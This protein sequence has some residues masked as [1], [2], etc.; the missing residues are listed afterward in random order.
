[1]PGNLKPFASF[2]KRPFGGVFLFR[3][4]FWSG[5][6]LCLM[7]LSW[8]S[9]SHYRPWVNFEAEFLSFLGLAML[10]LASLAAQPRQRWPLPALCLAAL[11]LLPF[12]QLAAGILTFAGDAFVGFVYVL[13]FA[14]SFAIGSS[15]GRRRQLPEDIAWPWLLVLGVPAFLSALVGVLQWAQL[16]DVLGIYAV[17]LDLGDRPMGNMGQPNQ[18]ATLLVMG[19]CAF[20]YLFE[21][22]RSGKLL[23]LTVATVITVVLAFTQ[24]RAGLLGATLAAVFL[25]LKLR[26]T[27]ARRL[28]AW[29]APA[30]L[31]AT[32][33]LWRAGSW[34]NDV[35]LTEANR[36]IGLV[37]DNSRGMIYLQ[38]LAGV[39][40]APALGYGWNQTTTA[41]RNGAMVFPGNL[42]YNNAHSIVVDL[43]AWAGVP[44]GLMIMFGLVA[45]FVDRAARVKHTPAVL[46]TAALIPFAVHSLFEFPFA[47]A[48]FLLSAGLLAGYVEGS[49]EA[50]PQRV[51]GALE[52]RR[53]LALAIALAWGC[54]GMTLSWSYL[55]VQRDF[56][57]VRFENLRI[58]QT[59]QGYE[60]PRVI[61]LTHMEAMLRAARMRPHPGM[62]AQEIELLRK[63]ATRFA[64]GAL[65]YRYA[66]ALA[67]NGDP[68]GAAREFAIMRGM[69]GDGFYRALM[70]ELRQLQEE[71]YPQLAAVQ[72]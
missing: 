53:S 54:L 17:H 13:A 5:A 34:I 64:W 38:A 35:L 43:V 39:W 37:D 62:S 10:F 21:Q 52:V 31:A 1:M 59:P 46:A 65:G 50:S 15:Q 70:I 58:G 41:H 18:L 23:T 67:L 27:G 55:R 40:Q 32:W 24:S 60:V 72:A 45:W 57:V 3:A 12:V 33:V 44:L 11:S 69:F 29:H 2:E 63:V 19:M 47:Y 51:R 42:T 28:K 7:G 48:Y 16:S 22:G 66:V 71:K 8:L 20:A 6:G 9:A 61:L 68:A 30:W 49:L 25:W 4:R 36:N 26:K 14:A 56:A